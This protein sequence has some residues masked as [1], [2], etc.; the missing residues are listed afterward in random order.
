MER[1]TSLR[2]SC[3]HCDA[4]ARVRK[5]QQLTPLYREAVVECQ[6][7]DCGWRGKLAL[8]MTQTL[9]FSQSPNPD[10]SL[11]LAPRLRNTFMQQMSAH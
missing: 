7:P 9:T 5:S 4:F 1:K 8:E 3:P 10:I 2:L 11:P 6:N